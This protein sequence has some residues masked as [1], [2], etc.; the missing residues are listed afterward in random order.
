M[1]RVVASVPEQKKDVVDVP[2]NFPSILCVPE[3]SILLMQFDLVDDAPMYKVSIRFGESLM[4]YTFPESVASDWLKKQM[5][6]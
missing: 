1:F 5:G 4:H 6:R 3:A 2:D